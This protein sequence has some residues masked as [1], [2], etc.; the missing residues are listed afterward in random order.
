MFC[1]NSEVILGVCT[2]IK[3]CLKNH[4][5]FLGTWSQRGCCQPSPTRR[6]WGQG[7]SWATG[8]ANAGEAPLPAVDVLH[9]FLTDQ[10]H[11]D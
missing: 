9:V 6:S 8:P 11:P 4:R 7:Q 2:L 5:P 3:E 1:E 10:L